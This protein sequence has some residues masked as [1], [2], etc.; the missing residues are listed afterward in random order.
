MKVGDLVRLT[1]EYTITTTNPGRFD[2]LK[3]TGVVTGIGMDHH[4][5]DRVEVYWF[6][7]QQK[8]LLPRDSVEVLCEGR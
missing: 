6:N 3:G 5:E 4:G 8:T 2:L 7:T 1:D